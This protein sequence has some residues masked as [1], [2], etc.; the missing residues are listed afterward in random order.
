MQGLVSFYFTSMMT[1]VAVAAYMLPTVV[2]WLRHAP[3]IAAVM[4]INLTLGWTVLGWWA[5]LV[6]SL[7]KAESPVVQVFSQVNAPASTPPVNGVWAPH[8]FTQPGPDPRLLPP[9]SGVPPQE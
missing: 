3:D 5:A 7:R 6:L 8:H 2:A 1:A 9:F 4:I